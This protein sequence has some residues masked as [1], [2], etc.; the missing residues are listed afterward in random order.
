MTTQKFNVRAGIAILVLL[1]LNCYMNMVEIEAIRA[2]LDKP[3]KP[4]QFICVKTGEV[5]SKHNVILSC[6]EIK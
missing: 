5:R 2:Q 4:N 3:A 1:C 6:G